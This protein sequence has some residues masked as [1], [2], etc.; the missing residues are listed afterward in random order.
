MKLYVTILIVAIAAAASAQTP[1]PIPEEQNQSN[2]NWIYHCL[3]GN[4]RTKQC[5][6]VSAPELQCH[7][8]VDQIFDVNTC[9]AGY[10]KDRNGKCRKIWNP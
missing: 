1:K 3:A 4:R 9:Q 2:C 7:S 10:A 5:I 6:E 8:R